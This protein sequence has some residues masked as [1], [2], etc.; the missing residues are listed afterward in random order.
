MSLARQSFWLRYSTKK[1]YRKEYNHNTAV[2]YYD[3]LWARGKVKNK[4]KGTEDM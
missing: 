4:L 2:I 3:R 1:W